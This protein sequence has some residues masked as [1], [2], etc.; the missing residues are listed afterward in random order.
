MVLV[1]VEVN[2][3]GRDRMIQKH[4]SFAIVR[5]NSWLGG[6]Y[7]THTRFRGSERSCS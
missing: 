7:D 6:K 5:V 3:P 1:L 2:R 4:A